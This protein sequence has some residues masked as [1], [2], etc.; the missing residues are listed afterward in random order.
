[1]YEFNVTG[2]EKYIYLI[3]SLIIIGLIIYFFYYREN[4]TELKENYVN[5]YSGVNKCGEAD[6]GPMDRPRIQPSCFYYNIDKENEKLYSIMDNVAKK[7]DGELSRAQNI[8]TKLSGFAIQNT[9]KINSLLN[10]PIVSGIENN[11]GTG[12]DL[13]DSNSTNSFYNPENVNIYN[14][15]KAGVEKEIRAAIERYLMGVLDRIMKQNNINFSEEVSKQL[16]SQMKSQIANPIYSMFVDK[17]NK[18]SEK[19]ITNIMRSVVKD[20]D[21][22]KAVELLIDNA[23]LSN[24]SFKQ[25]LS[26]PKNIQVGDFVYFKH[27]LGQSISELCADADKPETMTVIVGG[28]V[29]SMDVVNNTVKLSYNFIMNPNKNERCQG[30]SSTR[31]STI[32]YDLGPEGMPKWFPLTD[33]NVNCGANAPLGLACAPA[34][35]EESEDNWVRKYIGGFNRVDNKMDCGVSPEGIDLPEEV[36]VASIHTNLE[37]LIADCG[38]EN[39]KLKEEIRKTQII[40]EGTVTI[41]NSIVES[42]PNITTVI[43]QQLQQGT[44][45]PALAE[46]TP[47]NS[48]GKIVNKPKPVMS[49]PRFKHPNDCEQSC[50]DVYE[51]NDKKRVLTKGSGDSKVEY[52]F[53]GGKLV[54]SDGVNTNIFDETYRGEK[55]DIVRIYLTSVGL[56]ALTRNLKKYVLENK[57]FRQLDDTDLTDYDSKFYG[58]KFDCCFPSK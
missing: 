11:L 53:Q 55:L 21:V 32:N 19:D 30:M 49:I 43:S 4:S 34:Q 50:L 47:D 40:N 14:F 41:E 31:P 26:Q 58:I 18:D 42:V 38:R 15:D 57:G 10:G 33:E 51:D 23:S 20:T 12:L 46:P 45:T 22:V 2:L 24:P 3:S 5:R 16:T 39:L 9:N 54:K 1:M 17:F 48:Q 29:C 25:Y 37:Y 6:A 13:L 36:P 27:K 44:S 56:F 28:R 8:N 52:Y 35:W 7:L